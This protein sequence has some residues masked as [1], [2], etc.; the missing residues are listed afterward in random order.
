MLI[1]KT[2]IF[3][4]L[5]IVVVYFWLLDKS[6]QWQNRTLLK[7]DVVIKVLKKL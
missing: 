7:S 6:E 5:F 2:S 3:V 4:Q 1:M